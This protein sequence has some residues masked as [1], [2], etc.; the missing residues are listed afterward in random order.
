MCFLGLPPIASL[1]ALA[2]LGI[3]LR[4]ALFSDA[5]LSMLSVTGL[6]AGAGLGFLG[7]NALH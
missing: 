7:R 1:V 2:Q 4:A 6:G 5:T 3:T